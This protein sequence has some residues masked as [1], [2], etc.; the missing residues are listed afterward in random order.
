[1]DTIDRKKAELGLLT[2]K[3][4]VRVIDLQSPPLLEKSMNQRYEAPRAT[5]KVDLESKKMHESC[6]NIRIV[7]SDAFVVAPDNN[8]CNDSNLL[9]VDKYK[10]RSMDDI[11]GSAETV[12]KLRYVVSDRI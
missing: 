6:N 3:D 5:V 12:S 7:K 10:P 2:V 9:W 4:E 1:M 8:E 11:I